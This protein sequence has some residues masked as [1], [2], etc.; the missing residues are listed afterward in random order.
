MPEFEKNDRFKMNIVSC[1]FASFISNLKAADRNPYSWNMEFYLYD[2]NK[3][4]EARFTKCGI[5]NLLKDLDLFEFAPAI[6]KLDYTVA[7]VSGVSVFKREYTIATGGLFC[8]CG[9]YKK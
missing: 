1:M 2:N 7:D 8:D 9:C 4:Y 3:V 6:C 5:Y